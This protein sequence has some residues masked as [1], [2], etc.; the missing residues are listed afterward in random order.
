[1]VMDLQDVHANLE[2]QVAQSNIRLSGTSSHVFTADPQDNEEDTIPV[3]MK[4]SV[5]R[6]TSTLKTAL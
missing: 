3:T 5:L 2:D 4:A 6:I 1:M